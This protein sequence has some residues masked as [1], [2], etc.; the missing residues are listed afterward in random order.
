[1]CRRAN[2]LLDNSGGAVLSGAQNVLLY[3]DGPSTSLLCQTIGASDCLASTGATGFSLVNMTVGFGPTATA[4]TSGYALDV[5]SCTNCSLDGV[6]LNNGDLSG[7]RLASSV[8]TSLHNVSIANFE[9]NGLFAIND[10]DLRVSGLACTN[11]ADACF[12]TSWYDSQYSLYGVPCQDITAEGISSANDTETLLINSC[13]NVTVNGF[14][15]VGSGR[16]AVFVGEDN[17]T[18]TTQWPDRISISNGAIYGS[19]YGTNSR[20]SATAQALYINVGAAPAAGVVSHIALSNITASH[21]ASWG[22]QMAEFNNDDV[23][24]SNVQFYDVGNGNNTGCLQTEGNQVNLA[25]VYCTKVGSYGLYD[26]NTVRL[27][28]TGLNFSAVSQVSGHQRYLCGRY[29]HRL[30]QPDQHRYQRYQQHSIFERSVRRLDGGPAYHVE[31]IDQLCDSDRLPCADR[32]Q[33]RH[34][35]HLQR[36]GSLDGV[37][38]WRHD[39]E[40]RPTELLFFADRWRDAYQLREWRS[41]LLPVQVLELGRATDGIRWLARPVPYALD[42]ELQL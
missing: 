23:Q 18:T 42:R 11:N 20:N 39:S 10:Q 36:S 5:Q 31:H 16:E 35:I 17:T 9:A 19:G 21:I 3:G 12:E 28:G 41:A 24:L 34:H 26:T 2:Y 29:R 38:Q 27:T 1:M 40:L 22:L 37:P 6:T 4:R 15:S 25:A 8:H 33:C 7:L 14:T 13:N 32:C 30:Y